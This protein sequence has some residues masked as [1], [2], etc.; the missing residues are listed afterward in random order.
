[1]A[2]RTG[3]QIMGTGGHRPLVGMAVDQKELNQIINDL[4]KLLPP[5]TG[6][7]HTLSLIHI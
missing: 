3:K 2:V 4:E 1:M 6:P 7:K 5:K